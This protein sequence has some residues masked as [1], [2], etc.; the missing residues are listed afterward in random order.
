MEQVF[1]FVRSALSGDGAIQAAI[2]IG[3]FFVYWELCKANKSLEEIV[4]QSADR[5]AEG[6]AC[7]LGDDADHPSLGYAPR[8]FQRHDRR[9]ARGGRGEGAEL[10]EARDDL[11][12]RL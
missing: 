11:G 6:E 12:G 7:E 8:C 3:I 1:E 9:E 4:R 2:W 10:G 5:P